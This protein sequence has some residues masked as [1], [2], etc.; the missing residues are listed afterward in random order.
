MKEGFRQA[1]KLTESVINGIA[2]DEEQWDSMHMLL[3]THR[4][5]DHPTTKFPYTH[6]QSQCQSRV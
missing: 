2:E 6:T 4:E 5:T 1:V 3:E